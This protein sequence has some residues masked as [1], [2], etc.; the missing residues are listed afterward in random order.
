MI[1]AK[2]VF[3]GLA[4]SLVLFSCS[5]SS[6][7]YYEEDVTAGKRW[8]WWIHYDLWST[9]TDTPKLD[10]FD[11]T[12]PGLSV[13]HWRELDSAHFLNALIRV[14]RRFTGPHG[15]YSGK[16]FPPITEERLG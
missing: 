10:C 7:K 4:A 2:R 14:N 3:L 12:T 9:Q 5:C 16:L 11:P 8:W 15:T 6:I 13:V 1:T